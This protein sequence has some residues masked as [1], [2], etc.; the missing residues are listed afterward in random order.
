MSYDASNKHMCIW[1]ERDDVCGYGY[2]FF[3]F[4][5]LLEFT[6]SQKQHYH[7]TEE[8]FKNLKSHLSETELKILEDY[9]VPVIIYNLEY[10]Y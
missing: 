4:R 2:S 3:Q 6:T 5:S 7:L 1:R 9:Q 8:Q 10:Y